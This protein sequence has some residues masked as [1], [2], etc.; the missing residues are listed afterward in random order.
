M[1]RRTPR[2][3]RR[4]ALGQNFL[5]DQN[6]VTD[7]I[8]T[9]HPPPGSLVVDLGAGS[10]ALTSQLAKRKARVIAVELDP[11]WARVLCSRAPSWGDVTVVRGDVLRVP[12]PAERFYVVS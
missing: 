4:R 5:H 1:P 6:V 2:D 10:G 9:L 3:E 11:A 12:F 7:V 8:G